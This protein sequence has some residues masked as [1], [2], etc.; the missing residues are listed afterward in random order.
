MDLVVLIYALTT[1]L[2]SFERFG[3][4]SQLQRAAVS[5]P[6]N[7]AEGSRRHSRRHFSNF[8]A[9]AH[10]SAAE[11]ETQLL[12]INRLYPQ[13]SIHSEL[14]MVTEIQKMLDT[15]IK[16]LTPNP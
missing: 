15:L 3:L 9:F 14:E 1:K 5:I 6:S 13:H 7:I 4:S 16:R 12:I 11:V 2:P 10:G 8:C